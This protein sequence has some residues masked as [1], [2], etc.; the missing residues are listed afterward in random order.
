MFIQILRL[1]ITKC[2][3]ENRPIA[4]TAGIWTTATGKKTG[5]GHRGVIKN[6]Q[7]I[8]RWEPGKFGIV[9]KRKGIQL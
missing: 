7:C 3:P 9:R 8:G 4:I 2:P 6:G 5:I 1:I